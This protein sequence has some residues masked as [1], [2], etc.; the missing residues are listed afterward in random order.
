MARVT[1]G[2]S[3]PR[4][5]VGVVLVGHAL[6]GLALVW[7]L[8]RQ[9][10]VDEHGVA[11]VLDGLGRVIGHSDMLTPVF[12]TAGSPTPNARLHG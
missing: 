11:Y 8:I 12:D 3:R 7:D 9:L 1:G 2:I 6:H 5:D 4:H 10:R